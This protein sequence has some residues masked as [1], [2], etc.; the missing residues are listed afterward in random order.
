ML[1][2]FVSCHENV[3]VKKDTN[4]LKHWTHFVGCLLISSSTREQRQ[5]ENELFV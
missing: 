3:H 5:I 4:L 2:P 1:R